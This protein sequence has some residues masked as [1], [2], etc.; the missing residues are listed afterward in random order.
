MPTFKKIVNMPVF[1][2]FWDGHT[3][4]KLIK[5]AENRC[6]FLDSGYETIIGID[7]E[8]EVVGKMVFEGK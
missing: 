7:E 8:F 1:T 2:V 4:T 6:F 3:E 5:M